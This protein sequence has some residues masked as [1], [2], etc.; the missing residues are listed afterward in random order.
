MILRP[1]RSTLPDPLFPYTTLFRSV[2]FVDAGNAYES[3]FPKGS[4]LRFGAGIGARYYTNF[5]PLR[6]DVATPLNPRPGDGARF[7]PASSPAHRAFDT[8]K[9]PLAD[10]KLLESG[11]LEPRSAERRVGKECGGPGDTWGSRHN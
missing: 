6:I 7:Y 1:P 4:D 2:P 5:G 3:T 8:R 10:A 9:L 11:S